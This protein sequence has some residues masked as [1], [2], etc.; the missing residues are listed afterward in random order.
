[1][2]ISI[3]G[4]VG[5]RNRRKTIE[6]LNAHSS[7]IN[8]IQSYSIN[9]GELPETIDDIQPLDRDYYAFEDIDYNEYSFVI[10]NQ[11]N[12]NYDI[13]VCGLPM[14][15]DSKELMKFHRIPSVYNTGA[16]DEVEFEVS[17]ICIIY[18]DF[19]KNRF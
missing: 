10:L 12:G 19:N 16:S 3:G 15:T 9:N 8:A 5:E 13:E 1:M 2:F 14:L 4:P 17:D 7:I 11:D 18:T 6:V